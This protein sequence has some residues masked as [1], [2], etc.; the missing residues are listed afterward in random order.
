MFVAMKQTMLIKQSDGGTDQNNTSPRV[1]L[2]SCL[3]IVRLKL[4][5]VV[6]VRN[7]PG[8]SVFNPV[9]HVMG[10]LSLALMVLAVCRDEP[11]EKVI[12]HEIRKCGSV[13]KFVEEF[14]DKKS[15]SLL[16]M[17]KRWKHPVL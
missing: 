4:V 17:N 3:L 7:A 11:K 5:G 2:A 16:L 13:K 15:V 10:S 1:T 8:Q 14:K 12:E 6:L 9:E